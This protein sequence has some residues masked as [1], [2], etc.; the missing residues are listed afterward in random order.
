[1]ELAKQIEEIRL[2]AVSDLLSKEKVARITARID[3]VVGG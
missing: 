2:I 3:G 1:V